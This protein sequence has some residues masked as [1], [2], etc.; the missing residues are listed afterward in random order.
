MIE[1]LG[2]GERGRG[3]GGKGGRGEGGRGEWGGGFTLKLVCILLVSQGK[4]I[5]LFGFD[6]I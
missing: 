4:P 6:Q 1:V 3:E 2:L 5:L